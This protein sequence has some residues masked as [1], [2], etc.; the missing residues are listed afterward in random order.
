MRYLVGTDNNTWRLPDAVNAA[1]EGDTIEFQAG[2]SPVVD[3]IVISKDLHFEGK[4]TLAEGGNQNFTNVI[5]GKFNINQQDK[6]DRH[7]K[8]RRYGICGL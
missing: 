4:V 8:K 6:R 7:N 3:C 5:T 1:A 2:Y